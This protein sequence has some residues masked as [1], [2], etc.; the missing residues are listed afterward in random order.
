[1]KL[2]KD[3]KMLSLES[4]DLKVSLKSIHSG[5]LKYVN[6]ELVIPKLSNLILIRLYLRKDSMNNETI[7]KLKFLVKSML[8]VISSSC[9]TKY[10]DFSGIIDPN[11]SEDIKESADILDK[12]LS[13]DID[14]QE[15]VSIESISNL[16][17]Y[18]LYSDQILN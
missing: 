18:D 12:F 10:K 16:L 6:D 2:L 4:S 7:A 9:N 17:G 11:S 15:D 3:K 5:G 1:M 8:T 13:I 14:G